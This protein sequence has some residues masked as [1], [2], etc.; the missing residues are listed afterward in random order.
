M[1]VATVSTLAQETRFYLDFCIMSIEKKRINFYYIVVE[2][3]DI[4]CKDE[5]VVVSAFHF[6]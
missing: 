6:L 4:F 3:N 2:R 5:S 1:E